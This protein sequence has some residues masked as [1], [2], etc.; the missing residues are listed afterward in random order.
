MFTQS[1][2]LKPLQ[3]L[4]IASMFNPFFTRTMHKTLLF[5]LLLLF[6]TNTYAQENSLS[7][8][9]VDVNQTQTMSSSEKESVA[10]SVE[11]DENEDQ[12]A[13]SGPKA[14]FSLITIQNSVGGFYPVFLGNIKTKKNFDVTFYN[15][16]WTNPS[17]GTAVVGGDLLLEQGVGLGFHFL[18]NDLYVNPT[19]GLAHGKFL[20]GGEST[21][22]AEGVVPNLNVIYNNDWFEFEGYIS[23]Y[24]AVKGDE[25]NQRDFIL[26]WIVP[27]VKINQ[28]LSV[29][30]FYEQFT[31][32]RAQN[33]PTGPV[34]VWLGGYVKLKFNSGIH[35]R[36][37]FGSN[38]N[39]D[40]NPA[41]E[42]Y[43][44]S[45]FLPF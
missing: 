27:G 42:F 10:I 5:A 23:W 36:L 38:T 34:Y 35:A 16:F 39:T 26:N 45:V 1:V 6:V 13:E 31:L 14:S 25:A 37:A 19:L 33:S 28:S 8:E 24:K 20:S 41:G 44:A 3:S 32:T 2:A 17:F 22:L 15:I 4:N 18:N 11:D 12:N 30:G 9:D 21:R 43:K 7:E 29:G 40:I